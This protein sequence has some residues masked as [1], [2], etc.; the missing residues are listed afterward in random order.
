ML[1]LLARLEGRLRVYPRMVGRHVC[2]ITSARATTRSN[3]MLSDFEEYLREEALD[4]DVQVVG[5]HPEHCFHGDEH[6]A[7]SNFCQRSPYPM[8]H[9]L[10]QESVTI[11]SGSSNAAHVVRNNQILMTKLHD[12]Y[13]NASPPS[14]LD[15]GR[16]EEMTDP[17]AVSDWIAKAKEK[18]ASISFADFL[19]SVG[20][21]LYAN[22]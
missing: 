9:L 4:E 19:Q 3:E 12:L 6:D 18:R 8:V 5:F 15:G 16:W 10:R 14:T 22:S 21:K 2:P 1:P 17:Q 20:R 7:P 13:R 11:A